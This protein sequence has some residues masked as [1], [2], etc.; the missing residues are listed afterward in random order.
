MIPAGVFLSPSPCPFLLLLRKKENRLEVQ[1]VN[2]H[3]SAIQKG[4]FTMSILEEKLPV[5]IRETLQDHGTES[6]QNISPDIIVRKTRFR[7]DELTNIFAA[8]YDKDIS[9]ESDNSGKMYLYVRFKNISGEPLTGF[10]IHLYRNH[11]GLSNRPGDWAASEMH[12]EDGKPVY[13]GRLEAGEIGATPAFVY[14]KKTEGF[15]PNCFVAVATREEKPDYSSVNC[16]DKYI[17][18]VNKI[19]VAARNVC[20]IS[21][22]SPISTNTVVV[23]N[24]D[25]QWERRMWL[26][27]EIEG[28]TPSG[29]S[30]GVRQPEF[31][32]DETRTYLKGDSRTDIIACRF[33]MPPNAQRRFEIWFEAS[34]TD[35]AHIVCRCT[36]LMENG[37]GFDAALA[38]YLVDM[39]TGSAAPGGTE[40]LSL[41]LTRGYLLGC[42]YFKGNEVV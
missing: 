42:C 11:L 23:D 10:Y 37:S 25:R 16:H 28:E 21:G 19:N 32:I 40:N 22:Q 17:R 6:C 14:D 15:H 12:T 13:I 2:H 5:L 31:G 39:R 7:K 3:T 34:R 41:P 24:P 1:L 9:V 30:Y 8:T 35:R 4:D 29:V 27:V 18:W 33:F 26:I 20:V 38:P 36:Y